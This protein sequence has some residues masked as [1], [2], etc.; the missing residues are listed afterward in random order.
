MSEFP[1]GSEWRK[2]DL[3]LHAPGTKL[4]DQYRSSSDETELDEFCSIL[5]DSDVA[6]IGVTDYFSFDAYF[7]VQERYST[8]YSDNKK[9]LLPNVELRLSMSVNKADQEVN[10]HLVFNPSAI[11]REL[12]NKF[13]SNLR[14]EET[15]G[16]TRTRVSCADLKSAHDYEG[17]SVSLNSIDEAIKATFGEFATSPLVRQEFL[18]VIAS[19]KGD[20][21]RPGGSG[22]RRKNLLPTKSISIVMHSSP[23][24]AH[25]NIFS[26]EVASKP[27]RKFHPSLC[28]MGAT[29]IV[30]RICEETWGNL[31][32]R[33]V[34]TGTSPG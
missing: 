4:S 25:A 23:M 29:L 6:V 32:V 30:L 27:M 28:S 16:A 20:G 13:L 11:T 9:L 26:I 1:R 19:A 15:Q 17:A 33:K 34:V 10:L 3:H 14:T 24:Q 22:I 7:A 18:V 5:H 21:I 2:W 31:T 12:A 8:L